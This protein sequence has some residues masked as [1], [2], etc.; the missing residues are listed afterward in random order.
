MLRK[1]KERNKNQ[2]RVDVSSLL[3][4][5]KKLRVRSGVYSKGRFG[6]LA[7]LRET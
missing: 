5:R 2:R 1:W 3:E 6:F 4:V 7:V